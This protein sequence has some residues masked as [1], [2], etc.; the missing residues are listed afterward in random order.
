VNEDHSK[1]FAMFQEGLLFVESPNLDWQTMRGY[2]YRK[3]IV[4]YNDSHYEITESRS[5][6]SY[7]DWVHYQPCVQKI[8]KRTRV[9]SYWECA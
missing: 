2:Q 7:Y 5:Q 1:I 9:E 6:D 8:V 4:A 3:N